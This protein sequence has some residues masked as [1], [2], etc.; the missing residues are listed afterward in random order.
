MTYTVL[1]GTLNSNIL[2]HTIP[3]RKIHNWKITDQI[4]RGWKM[5]WSVVIRQLFA[6]SSCFS[7]LPFMAYLNL[8]FSTVSFGFRFFFVSLRQTKLVSWWAH[9]KIAVSYRIV[10]PALFYIAPSTVILQR[11]ENSGCQSGIFSL[12]LTSAAAA[13]AATSLNHHLERCW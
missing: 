6:R 9:V 3:F 7:G 11:V 4:A 2:Y 10:S 5:T 12:P 8:F 13:A 1:S